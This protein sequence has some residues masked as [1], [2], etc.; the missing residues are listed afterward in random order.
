[1]LPADTSLLEEYRLARPST[2]KAMTGPLTVTAEHLQACV[3]CQ[4]HIIASA[5]AAGG[6]PDYVV[7]KVDHI[8]TP[9]TPILGKFK[10]YRI[11]PST[12]WL[13]GMFEW[14]DAETMAWG[15][16]HLSRTCSIEIDYDQEV[17]DKKFAARLVAVAL[18]PAETLPAMPGAGSTR[19]VASAAS[20]AGLRV[21]LTCG[22]DDPKQA[23]TTDTNTEEKTMEE[24]KAAIAQLTEGLA[25]TNA[26]LAELGTK[27]EGVTAAK[28]EADAAVATAAAA[29]ADAAS[30][31][32]F[33]AKLAA[34][35]TDGK[36]TQGEAETL[37]AVAQAIPVES[38][39]K[40]AASF[41]AR[42]KPE[43]GKEKLVNVEPTKKLSVEEKAVE[44][45]KA[46]RAKLAANKG[47]DYAAA[48]RAAQA[49]HPE[50]FDFSEVK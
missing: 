31:T 11:E 7:G 47:T 41:D 37:T 23:S 17:Y 32:D 45:Q 15:H 10:S 30:L 3:D 19:A 12:G 20:T 43:A 8:D 22:D 5:E 2:V 33:G 34:A 38:R 18:L 39:A 42:P 14:T 6:T 1:M 9:N 44:C 24:M 29:T 36:V 40:L 49:E 27:L 35:V 26:R 50:M 13:M 48:V 25:A 21:R 4:A 16:T 46:I 28:S